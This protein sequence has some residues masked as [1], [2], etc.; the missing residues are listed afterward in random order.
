MTWNSICT[1]QCGDG[2]RTPNEGCDDGNSLENDGC[3]NNC[4]EMSGW[5]CLEDI[6][7]MSYCTHAC[8]NGVWDS[9]ENE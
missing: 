3:Y 2:Y 7:M 9:K 5:S 4:T 1:S 8:G 6:N